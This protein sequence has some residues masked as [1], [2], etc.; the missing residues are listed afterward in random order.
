MCLAQHINERQPQVE[1]GCSRQLFQ[2][3]SSEYEDNHFTQTYRLRRMVVHQ[4]KKIQCACFA[5][6][7]IQRMERTGMDKIPHLGYVDC[8]GI[9]KTGNICD[10][11]KNRKVF[12][13]N[14][15]V[16]R[17]CAIIYTLNNFDFSS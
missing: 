10:F 13:K 8:G 11:C 12:S 6:E 3:R 7:N 14:R 2:G 5:M 9:E 4:M 1:C 15:M 16:S 17:C